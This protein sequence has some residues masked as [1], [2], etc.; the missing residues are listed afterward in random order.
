MTVRAYERTAAAR[1]ALA[2]DVTQS[3]VSGAAVWID[4]YHPTAAEDSLI[5]SL[6]G[7]INIPTPQDRTA[8]ED[9]A[10]FYEDD[11]AL[12]L[13]TTL[14]G[15]TEDG[16]P[17]TD[18]VTFILVRGRLVTVRTLV[19]KAFEIGEGRASARITGAATG[20]DAFIALLEGIVERIADLLQEATNEAEALSARVFRE[21]APERDL[22]KALR[23]VGRLG[24]TAARCNA[25]LSGLK[26]MLVYLTGVCTR[27][28]LRGDRLMEISTDIGELERSSAALQ[29]NIGFLL[30]SALGMISASQ[31]TTLKA[32]SVATILFAP[33]MLIA[34]FFGMNFRTFGMLDP[35]HGVSLTAL[36]MVASAII[37]WLL[38]RWRSWF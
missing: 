3:I 10:R 35:V 9:S 7:G 27:H 19:L 20:G 17:S 12:Y 18:S 8:L 25:S 32:L 13:T 14:P 36:S 24:A 16:L 38:G 1:V 26:R 30:N 4:L 2:A 11:G 5:E 31:N 34:S 28:S 22:R 33:P 6:L 37:V 29:S 23:T 21:E 15:R